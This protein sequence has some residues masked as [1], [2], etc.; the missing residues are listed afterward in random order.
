MADHRTVGSFVS[1]LGR[2]HDGLDAIESWNRASAV[3][4][5]GKNAELA[6]NLPRSQR[7]AAP[8]MADNA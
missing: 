4:F 6:I 3:I 2:I 7:I 1:A 5:Y 8:A